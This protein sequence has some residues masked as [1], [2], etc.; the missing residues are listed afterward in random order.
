MIHQDREIKLLFG[1]DK[2][3]GSPSVIRNMIVIKM[4]ELAAQ[5]FLD[6]IHE[7][8]SPTLA[9]IAITSNVTPVPLRNVDTEPA[10]TVEMV[11]SVVA[12]AISGHEVCLDFYHVSAF[13]VLSAPTTKKLGLDPVVRVDLRTSYFLSLIASLEN[14]AKNFT[15]PVMENENA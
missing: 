1:Q 8:Q 10:E 2:I 6:S 7:I 14:A 5:Q 11:S 4:T 12:V 13:S 3:G 15:L 9:E